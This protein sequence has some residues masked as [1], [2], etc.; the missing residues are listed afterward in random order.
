MDL[1]EGEM[2]AIRRGRLRLSQDELA[3][4]AGVSRQTISSTE[5]G[6]TSEPSLSAILAALDA[7]EA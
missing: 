6:L 1:H 2:I 5:R 7:A 3:D 4:M